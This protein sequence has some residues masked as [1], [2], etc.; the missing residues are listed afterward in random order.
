MDD[1]DRQMFLDFVPDEVRDHY[2]A[3][4][5]ALQLKRERAEAT[6]R[7]NAEERE[8]KEQER[9]LQR[10]R[11]RE[12]AHESLFDSGGGGDL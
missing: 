8:R 10:I 12:K 1:I 11:E 7:R 3:R 6:R 9:E 5:R 4:D 2:R